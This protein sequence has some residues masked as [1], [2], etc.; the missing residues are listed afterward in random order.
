M[1]TIRAEGAVEIAAG[2]VARGRL[3]V[4][5][6]KSVTQRYFNLSLVG[7]VAVEVHGP[8]L[9]DDP[10]H[11]LDAMRICGFEVEID[12]SAGVVRL[13]P[14]SKP[15]GGAID[16]GAG[17]TMFRFLTAALT[18]V[19][20]RWRLD[21]V[22]R[23][24]ERTVGPLVEALR[25]LGATIA[26]DARD[27]FAPLTITG[28]LDGGIATLDAG[29]SSQFLS[30]VLMAGLGARKPVEL[31]VDRL[32]STPYVDLT[33]EAIERFGGRVERLGQRAEETG[34]AIWRVA[35]TVLR[36]GRMEVEA[37]DSAAAYPA[38]AAA[39][40]KGTVLL[41][42]LRRDSAQG[43]RRLLD[44]LAAMGARVAWRTE[45]GRDLVEVTGDSLR[46]IDVDMGDLPD[47]VPTVAALAPF[48]TGVTR[49]RNVAHLRIKES[50]RL[51]AMAS[52]LG[53]VGASAVETEDG[54]EVRGSWADQAPPSAPVVVSSW[55]DHRIA[56]AMALVGL[57]RPG[58]RVAE[59]SVVGKS[60]P[61]FWRDLE[62]L[63]R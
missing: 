36:G 51:A 43:D 11:F 47:Q 40:T 7:R 10:R 31:H 20:G 8:L 6:S 17:G 27:G 14:V 23:L 24:R 44:L 1:S 2:R 62:G 46:G 15:S 13:R 35:P 52:E 18:T 9:S 53:R 21:G 33:V 49:I 32:V 37:D 48:A 50:D 30:A 19:P 34:A 26:S 60:Y 22:P 5:G 57:R 38:A 56:M 42:G 4:P 58:I 61:T 28:P 59:P 12:E 54:L 16:C 63:L 29:V 55:D 39:L 25:P 45:E 41:E 3:R